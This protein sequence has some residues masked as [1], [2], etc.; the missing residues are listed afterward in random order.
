MDLW[1]CNRVI[2]C[3][4]LPEKPS[5]NYRTSHWSRRGEHQKSP[6]KRWPMVTL[7]S[8]HKNNPS[9]GQIGRGQH[10][11]LLKTIMHETNSGILRALFCVPGGIHRPDFLKLNLTMTVRHYPGQWPG[12][13][14]LCPYETVTPKPYSWGF[15]QW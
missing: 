10:P 9:M 2:H 14:S 4:V 13:G 1:R 8:K 15:L 5:Q 7:C 12:C 3:S 11:K 6:R